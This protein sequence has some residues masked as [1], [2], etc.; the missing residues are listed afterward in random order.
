MSEHDPIL[1][2]LVSGRGTARE[3]GGGGVPLRQSPSAPATSPSKLGEDLKRDF[4]GLV[5]AD[6]SPWH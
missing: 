4:P 3:A 2:E 5:T 6:G 1:P